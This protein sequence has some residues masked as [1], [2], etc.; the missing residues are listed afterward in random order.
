MSIQ[1]IVSNLML[2]HTFPQVALSDLGISLT[3]GVK[4][5]TANDMFTF[6]K[7]IY[8]YRLVCTS[9]FSPYGITKKTQK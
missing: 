2:M 1:E 6:K 4:T 7:I 8:I 5:E 3:E 9:I